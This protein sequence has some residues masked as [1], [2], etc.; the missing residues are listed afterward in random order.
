M[1]K[2]GLAGH[3]VLPKGKVLYHGSPAEYFNW[4]DADGEKWGFPAPKHIIHP[5][6]PTGPAWFADNVKFSLHAAVRY[7]KPN[8][9][10]EITLHE[11]TL[12]H[13]M[14]IMA[15]DDMDDMAAFLRDFHKKDATFNGFVEAA[16]ILNFGAGGM[17]GY[18]LT[19]DVVRGEPEYVLSN[20][21]MRLLERYPKSTTVTVYPIAKK[22][23]MLMAT[24][25]GKTTH[26]ATYKYSEGPGKLEWSY[27]GDVSCLYE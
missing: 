10:T 27:G 7:T 14:D 6:D 4:Q 21:G 1:S 2:P 19:R 9:R 3:A 24:V 17:R 13:P 23:S 18:A 22:E 16:T 25:K 8:V 11:Y 26:L 5:P 15:F 12:D 20:E